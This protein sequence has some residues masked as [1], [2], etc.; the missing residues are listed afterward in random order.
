MVGHITNLAGTLLVVFEDVDSKCSFCCSK[1]VIEKT[2][3]LAAD[4]MGPPLW[5]LALCLLLSW[6]IVVL[7]LIKGVKSSGKVSHQFV[8]GTNCHSGSNIL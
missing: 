8:S 3:T 7:C 4:E 6:I 1:D 2:D 5:R